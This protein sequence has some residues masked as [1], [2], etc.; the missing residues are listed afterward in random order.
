MVIN[1]VDLLLGNG[2]NQQNT[3][4]MEQVLF[5]RSVIRISFFILF[6][7]ILDRND[8]VDVYKWTQKNDYIL[9]AT[10]REIGMGGG[11][12]G[13]A[14]TLYDDMSR[15]QSAGTQTFNNPCL[16]SPDDDESDVG[17]PIDLIL[18]SLAPVKEESERSLSMQSSE[19]FQREPVAVSLTTSLNAELLSTETSQSRT[20]SVMSVKIQS[21]FKVS[22]VQVFGFSS[23][24]RNRK[25]IPKFVQKV[26]SGRSS[27]VR[28]SR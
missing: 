21:P 19:S 6:L 2:K 14:F 25:R 10:S 23:E 5:S 12:G 9:W 7:L 16:Y 22:Q 4:G 15:G 20:N 24:I 13:F 28:P 27:D 8:G 3:L 1:S 11:G 26:W 17:D 18:N